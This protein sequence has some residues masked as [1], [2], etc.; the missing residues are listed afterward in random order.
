VKIEVKEVE[1]SSLDRANKILAGIADGAR[2]AAYNAAK[3]AGQA[4]KTEAGRYAAKAYTISK[5]TF[6]KRVSVETKTHLDSYSA[7]GGYIK[8]G[9]G[10]HTVASVSIN[11]CGSVIP[12]LEF[13]TKFT[14]GG[15][16]TT[17]VKRNGAGGTLQHAFAARVYEKKAVFER[18]G[19]ARFPIE[20]KY[21][22]STAHMMREDSVVENMTKTIGE[23]FEKRMEH[24]IWR[25]LTG[26]GR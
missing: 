18:V 22:P 7:P 24:E 2:D 15:R 23:T 4:A 5:S 3:R 20:E 8:K 21:G 14:G 19:K 6:M 12:L 16:L 9:L 25:I 10:A 26:L 13:N 17:Q 1:G 11:F